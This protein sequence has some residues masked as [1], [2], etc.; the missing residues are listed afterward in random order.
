MTL[1]YYK[2]FHNYSTNPKLMLEFLQILLSCEWKHYLKAIRDVN[3]DQQTV[4][5]SQYL[6]FINISPIQDQ[7]YEIIL[8]IL[9]TLN[10][11]QMNYDY[12]FRS[13]DNLRSMVTL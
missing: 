12:L 1:Y 13:L 5:L 10:L 3:F 8:V 11:E 4:V 6:L 2:G 7:E 9:P